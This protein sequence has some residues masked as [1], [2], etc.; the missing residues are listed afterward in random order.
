M[1]SSSFWGQDVD[2]FWT[3]SG[4]E[5]LAGRSAKANE[6]VSFEL[7]LKDALWPA[8]EASLVDANIYKTI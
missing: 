6:R 4:L 3:S 2:L 1:T 5:V 7:T 8:P